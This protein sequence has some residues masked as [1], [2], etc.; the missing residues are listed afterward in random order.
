MK[1]PQKVT[2]VIMHKFE[3]IYRA[4]FFSSHIKAREYIYVPEQALP[5]IV[6]SSPVTFAKPILI[7][8]MRHE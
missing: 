5:L 4:H 6:L 8:S 3:G 7:I 1:R 2:S